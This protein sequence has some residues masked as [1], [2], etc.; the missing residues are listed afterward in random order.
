MFYYQNERSTGTE[1]YY[2]P[3]DVAE[4]LTKK[5]LEF[6]EKDQIWL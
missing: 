5:M 2:T 6:A 1:Q 3:K 4:N